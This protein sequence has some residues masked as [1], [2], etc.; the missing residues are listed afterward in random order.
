MLT[1]RIVVH[2]QKQK[3]GDRLFKI[4]KAFG[5]RNAPKLTIHLLDNEDLRS[6]AHLMTEQPEILKEKVLGKLSLSCLAVVE[7]STGLAK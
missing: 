6:L 4:I 1:R 2:D 5:V 3:L 7:N